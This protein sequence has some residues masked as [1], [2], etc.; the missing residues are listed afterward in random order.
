[1]SK[2]N[3]L[4]LTILA[5]LT[6]LVYIVDLFKLNYRLAGWEEFGEPPVLIS[7]VQYFIADTPNIIGYLDRSIGEEVTC[8]AAVAFVE[9]DTGEKYRCCDTGELISC[10]DGDFSSDIPTTDE[11]C[12]SELKDIFGVPDTLAGAKEYQIF[13]DCFGG[14]FAELTVVQLDESGKIHWKHLKVD[15]IQVMTSALRC[16]VGP[17]LLLAIA[18]ILYKLYQEKTTQP[19]RRI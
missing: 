2:K 9:S 15:T 3:I 13:G 17:A 16:V 18:Y 4:L 12:V 19:V 14:R 5:V 8:F 7:H 11:Q 10:L 1:M 6:L